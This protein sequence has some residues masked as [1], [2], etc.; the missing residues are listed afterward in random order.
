MAVPF[1]KPEGLVSP[2]AEFE[3]RVRASYD[4][5]TAMHTLA[6]RLEAVEPGYVE[7]SMP[8]QPELTQQHGYL[9]AGIVTTALDTACGY[10][11]F[12]L[13][14]VKAEV[15]TV[16]FKTNLLSPA[17]GENFTFCAKVV[18][19]GRTLSVC[20]AQAFAH[21]GEAPPKLIAHMT[22]TLMAV[23]RDP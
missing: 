11:A 10:A 22:A 12:S 23:I 3:Q 7:L 1:L 15:L 21:A 14:D 13:M 8:F 17:R 20:D 6:I 9:H 4:R 5:H 2:D 19:S 16:E 18:K